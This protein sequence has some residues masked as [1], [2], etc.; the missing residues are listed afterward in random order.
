MATSR[1]VSSKKKSTSRKNFPFFKVII[2][3]NSVLILLVCIYYFKTPIA[4]YLSFIP[5]KTVNYSSK[6]EADRIF[7]IINSHKEYSL[8][9]DVSE[10]QE[11]I[12]WQQVNKNKDSLPFTFVF[13]RATAGK[14]KIDAR[15]KTNWDDAKKHNLVRGAYHFYRPNEN[16]LLQAKNFIKTVKLEKGDLP[17]V[18]DIEHLPKKQSID[19]LKS[20]LK[21][22]LTV[23]ERHYKV[24]P[25]LYSGQHYHENF[26]ENE[27][28]E[29]PLWI[30]NYNNWV[31]EMEPHWDFWQFTESAKIPGIVTPVDLNLFQGSRKK[32]LYFTK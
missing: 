12:D 21:K 18:L 14:D 20:G 1:K 5:K 26:L 29:Y 16:S 7:N 8:G 23:I 30:A 17:P 32:L 25:I 13:I 28:R 10:Y 3:F 11:K 4:R 9:L 22:W 6:K 19:S 2:I 15:F 27:F 31:K 24:K